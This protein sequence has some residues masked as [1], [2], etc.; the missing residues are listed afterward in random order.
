VQ[1]SL[2]LKHLLL[3][4]PDQSIFDA[5]HIVFGQRFGALEIHPSLTHRS[6]ANVEIYR[7]SN[8]NKANQLVSLTDTGWQYLNQSWLWHTDSSFLGIPS[9]G[10]ILHEIETT[11]ED[12]NMRFANM[13]AA[14]YALDDATK[15]EIEGLW[16]VH[17]HDLSLAS[18]RNYPRSRIKCAMQIYPR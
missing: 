4:S 9:K 1:K 15:K 8:V 17:D 5:E 18:R 6:G 13:Y 12:G 10:S 2:W 11:N 14:Y 16:V 7:V 3:I